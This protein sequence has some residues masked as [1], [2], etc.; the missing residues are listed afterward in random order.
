MD[1]YA[2]DSHK[3]TLHPQHVARW[4]D[5]G[6]DWEKL[7]VLYPLYVEIS[8]NGG[9]NHRCSFCAVDYIG[10]RSVRLERQALR[11]CLADMALHGVKSV[12]FAGE[13]E[14]LLAPEIGATAAHAKKCRLDAAVTTN[15][16]ALNP[17][18]AKELLPHL[19]WLKASVNGGTPEVY[20]AVH[21]TKKQD[22]NR[23]MDNLA[24]AVDLR[25]GYHWDVTIGA[26]IVLLPENQDSVLQL[27][28]LCR[29]I[30]LDYLVVKPYSHHPRSVEPTLKNYQQ[31]DYRWRGALAEDLKQCESSE[32][33]V[34]YRHQTMRQ[35]EE[36]RPYKT[37]YATP[38]HWAYI[39]ASGD[40]Y[41]CGAHL[42]DERFNLGNINQQSF[43][44]IWEGERRRQCWEVMR[45][46]D[47]STC[48]K[49]CRMEAQNRYLWELKNPGPHV[50]FV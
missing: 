29:S 36:S 19:T 13:G 47:I 45:S 30:G 1:D 6:D 8:P 22:F 37:C 26:Q 7:R 9:C 15:A 31:I 10:Y 21:R 11:H 17:S 4:L 49:N 48:R 42:L 43:S 20:A 28:W 38:M 27:A 50:N 40:V 35:L 46:F 39:M 2:I 44:E 25:N 14:P 18:L 12:M 16:T 32:F 5:A 33:K 41:A 24:H 34:I 3:L 23:V